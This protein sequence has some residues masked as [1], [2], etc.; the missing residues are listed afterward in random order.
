MRITGRQ[1]RAARVFLGWTAAQ[2][3]EAA[4][5]GISTVQSIENAAGEPTV[6][7]DVQ[8]RIDVR[9]ESLAKIVHALEAAGITFLKD[10]GRGVGLRSKA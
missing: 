8:W 4:S 1:I 10:D 5:V 3:A 2:L 9:A 7:G 6:K